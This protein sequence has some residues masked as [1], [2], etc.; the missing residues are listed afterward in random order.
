MLKPL[1]ISDTTITFTPRMRD[2]HRSILFYLLM[3]CSA[4]PMRAQAQYL[5]G[6]V[7]DGETGQAVRAANI[8]V[9]N[10]RT[11]TD[12]SGRFGITGFTNFPITISVSHMGYEPASLTLYAPPDTLLYISLLSKTIGLAEVRVLGR[13]NSVKDSL[14]MRDAYADQF[15]FKPVKPWQALT[16]APMGIGI[17]LNMLFASFSREQKRSK[18]LKAALIRD[19]HDDYVDRRYTKELIQAQTDISDAELDVFHWFFRPTYEQ[20]HGF[21]DY[22]LLMYIRDKYKDFSTRREAYPT[23]MPVF[24]GFK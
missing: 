6:V 3:A 19:E 15:N 9:G 5:G 17:N 21:S 8:T 1:D 4:L 16:L 24:G 22:D 2:S 18:V 7:R 23:K 13:R 12:A 10:R 14:W 20:L 11:A